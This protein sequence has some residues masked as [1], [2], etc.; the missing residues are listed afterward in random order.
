MKQTDGD[1]ASI[2][3]KKAIVGGMYRTTQRIVEASQRKSKPEGTVVKL[4]WGSWGQGS[5][6]P[7]MG[8]AKAN[9]AQ[10]KN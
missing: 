6:A 3:V 2:A 4:G 10:A 9:P 1:V 7:Q 8:K 5:L